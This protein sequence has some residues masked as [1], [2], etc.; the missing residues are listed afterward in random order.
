MTVTADTTI[1]QPVRI[2]IVDD[3]QTMRALLRAVM[4]QDPELIVV[5]VAGSAQEARG[6]IKQTNPDVLILDL[7]MPEV[8][9]LEFLGH[10]MRLR[11]MPVVVFS[12]MVALRPEIATQAR[13]MGAVAVVAK[14]DRVHSAQFDQLRD[15]VKEAGHAF[16]HTGTKAAP[17]PDGHIVLIGASTGGVS[18]IEMVLASFDRGC[19]PIVIAQHMPQRFL[20]SFCRRLGHNTQLRAYMAREGQSLESG[21]IYLAPA[22]S[23]QTCVRFAAGMWRAT[24]VPQDADATYCPSVDQLFFSAVPWARQVGAMLLTGLGDDGAR[25]MKDLRSNGART[26]VQSAETCVV[27]GMPTAALHL[28]AAEQCAHPR[29]AGRDLLRLMGCAA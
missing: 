9:G 13:D 14:G 3:S 26:V 7:D 27:A 24:L 4:K 6:V 23:L 25:G 10:V 15:K 1:S 12:G 22:E 28:D 18:A 17:N 8:N 2:V 16:Q 29:D 20:I 5:G 21:A 19:P 11:P